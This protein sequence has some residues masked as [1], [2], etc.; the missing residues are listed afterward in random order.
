[1]VYNTQNY[2]V[3]GLC[4]ASGILKTRE[5]NVSETGLFLEYRT[6]TKSKRQ[7]LYSTSLFLLYIPG[8]LGPCI[9][10]NKQTGQQLIFYSARVSILASHAAF[11]SVHTQ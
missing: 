6:K 4:L 11:T 2:W 1:M 8:K 9:Y 10:R 7:T 5:H 3:F